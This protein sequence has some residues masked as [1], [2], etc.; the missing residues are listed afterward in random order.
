MNKNQVLEKIEQSGLVA[1]VRAESADQAMRITEAC[2]EGGVAAIELTYTVPGATA[3][4]EALA[5]RY[6]P[7]DIII[8]AGT[9]LDPVTARMAIMAGAL[10]VVSPCL[11][12]DVVRMCQ[13]YQVATMPGAMT[14]REMVEVMRSGGDVIKL[15]PGDLFGPSMI[16][17]VKGPLPQAR[18]MPTGGVSVENAAQW[19]QAGA[20]ALGAGS[21]LTAGAKTGDYGKITE[22]AKAFIEQIQKARG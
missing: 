7:E 17:T 19:I 1:V 15:F 22:T 20:V 2:I 16:K 18:I 5:S 12:E 9:V 21:S 6:R 10:Y 8:G 3:I 11:D 4:I 13:T 14:I